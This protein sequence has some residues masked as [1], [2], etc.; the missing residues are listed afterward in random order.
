MDGEG[1]RGGFRESTLDPAESGRRWRYRGIGWTRSC[2][3]IRLW[4][5][6]TVVVVALTIWGYVSIGPNGRLEPGR[7]EQHRTDFTVFTEAGAAFF[8]GRDPYR[9][10][11]PRG[12]HYLYPPLFALLVAPLSALD[13]ASQ[14]VVWY[15]INVVLAFGCFVEARRLLGLICRAGPR[16]P[17]WVAACGL[18]AAILPTL[19]CMQAGQLGLAILY[20]LTLGFRIVL[21]D[22]TRR[23]G[24]LGGLILALPAVLK[25][26]PSLPVAFLL[27]QRWSVVAWPRTRPRPWP[28][29]TAPTAGVLAGLAFFLLAVPAVLIGWRANQDHLD[30][31]YARIVVNEH[32]GPAANFNIHSYRNQSLANALGLAHTAVARWSAPDPSPTTSVGRPE[33]VASPAARVLIGLVLAVLLLVGGSL[34]RRGNDLDQATAYGL[35][36]CAILLV[37]PIAWGHYYSANTLAVL[38]VPS[39]LLRQGRPV[40]ARVA[41][42]IPPILSWTYYLGM[43]YAG[44]LGLLGLGTTVWFLA[45]CGSIL[46]NLVAAA[47]VSTRTHLDGRPGRARD[48]E[49]SL[50]I[51][52]ASPGPK[53]PWIPT[54][55]STI[56]SG[57][58]PCGDRGIAEARMGHR[59]VADQTASHRRSSDSKH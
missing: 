47:P 15:V 12:W 45:V 6:G 2:D 3:E 54:P 7:T 44:G 36:C 34:G 11:N 59:F 43:P 41:A 21:Q 17:R 23:G 39:W 9:V 25:L 48:G 18:L 13:T 1:V 57:Q 38:F 55:R 37:S 30:R 19:D 56:P 5:P 20:F 22:P 4:I 28:Q 31:W 32:V 46:G 35:A 24:F 26:V 14:V 51:D 27:F 8:D 58:D 53:P 33:P 16:T 40:Q 52:P 50:R 49:T 29:A 42:V 10:T